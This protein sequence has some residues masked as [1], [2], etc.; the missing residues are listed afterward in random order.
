M[1]VVLDKL[2]PVA[3][4]VL[5]LA[6]KHRLVCFLP[7][8][9]TVYLPDDEPD[10]FIPQTSAEL[11][12]YVEKMA[13]EAKEVLDLLRSDERS[14]RKSYGSQGRSDRSKPDPEV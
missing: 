8:P 2:L 11:F 5:P 12:D 13:P 9:P 10:E 7:A 14:K 4:V 6:R 3:N 1:A